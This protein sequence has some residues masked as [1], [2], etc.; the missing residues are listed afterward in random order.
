MEMKGRWRWKEGRDRGRVKTEGGW[1]RRMEM[2]GGWRWRELE[3]EGGWRWREGGDGGRVEMEGVSR[4]M[5]EK[6]GIERGKG[7]GREE[8]DELS[9]V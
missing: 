5:I 4:G 1:R 9:K 6:K 3:M 8:G 7:D 2:K